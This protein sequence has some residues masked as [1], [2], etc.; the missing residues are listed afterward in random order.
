MLQVFYLDV[1]YVLH[2]FHVFLQVFQMLVSS[3][4]SD[5]K[6]ILQVLHL[7]ISKIDQML[8]LPPYFLLSPPQGA[9]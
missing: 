7:D 9:G 1:A 2:G 8:H 3:I 5:F 6:H 4:S